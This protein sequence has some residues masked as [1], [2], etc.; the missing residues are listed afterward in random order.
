MGGT[1]QQVGGGGRDDD[2]VGALA[3]RDVRH[4]RHVLEHPG[5]DR[6]AGQRLEGGG[7]DEPQR[8]FGRDDADLVAGLGELTDDGGGLVGGDTPSDADDDP[9]AVRPRFTRLA[10]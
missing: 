9:L 1:R 6:L 2:Q 7:P 8:G 10:L 4:P 5:L 3:D